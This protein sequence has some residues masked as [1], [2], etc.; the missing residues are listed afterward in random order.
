MAEKIEIQEE[1]V[2]EGKNPFVEGI[3]RALLASVGAV[4][5]AQG[6]AEKFVKR[7]VE[8]GEIAEKDGRALLNDLAENRKQRAQESS[9][10]V[11][12]ELEKRMEGLLNRMNIPTKSDIEQLSNKVAELTKKIETLKE[13][14]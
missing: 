4:S 1:A 2:D 7:L 11:S 12:D 5:V 13:Q 10:R 9:K 6:E 8:K 3:R 14:K